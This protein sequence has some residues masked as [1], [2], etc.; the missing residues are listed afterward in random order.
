MLSRAE[1]DELV[2][3]L[4]ACSTFA[5][6]RLRGAVVER[7]P[8]HARRNVPHAP[9][10]RAF[11]SGLVTICAGYEGGLASLCEA[12][13]WYEG[14][15]YA[16]RAVYE[17][18]D[19]IGAGVSVPRD[20]RRGDMAG[21]AIARPATPVVWRPRYVHTLQRA[22]HFVD[23]IDLLAALR[24]WRG[25]AGS[26]AHVAAMV[27]LGGAGKTAV[28]ERWLAE[29][30]RSVGA[31][32]D[33]GLLVWSFFENPR[34]EAFLA[35]SVAYFASLGDETA[36]AEVTVER[37]ERALAAGP[38]HLLVLDGLE[39]VQSEGSAA[40]AYGELEDPVLR[41]LLAALARGLGR[42]RALVT[43]RFEL[44]DL[45]A[46][47]GDGLV[48]LRLSLID[49][50]S[51][52]DLLRRW[53]VHGDDRV[54]ARVCRQAGGHPLTL[55]MMG[56]YI[57]AF[58]GGDPGHVNEI[59]LDE[60]MRDDVL[61]RRL[62]AVLAEYA[63]ALSPLARELMTVLASL[64][65]GAAV[66]ALVSW[67][68]RGEPTA[69]RDRASVQRELKRLG[70]LGLVFTPQPGVY[71]THPFLRQYFRDLLDTS[72]TDPD[73][74]SPRPLSLDGRPWLPPSQASLLDTYE[75][76]L[77]HALD[78]GRTNDAFVLYARSMGSYDHLGM[79]LGDMIRGARVIRRFA[80]G[81]GGDPVSMVDGLPLGAHGKLAYE[82][83]L[84]S[85]ALG[86][87]AFAR[88]CYRV[89]LDLARS[90]R[91]LVMMATATRTLAYTERL[92][93]ALSVAREHAS[94]SLDLARQLAPWEPSDAH[95]SRALA[96]LGLICHDLGEVD[97]AASLFR[98]VLAHEALPRARRGL[99]W[100]E[101]LFELGRVGEAK[102]VTDINLTHC[103]AMRW[104]SHAAQCRLLLGHIAVSHG[105][106]AGAR[107]HLE[108]AQRWVQTTGE[109]ETQLRC[110]SLDARLALAEG[111]H[112]DAMGTASGGHHLACTTGAAWFAPGLAL[113]AAEAALA[114][115]LPMS[116]LELA[117]TGLGSES[118]WCR[119]TAHYSMGLS[120]RAMSDRAAADPHL[121]EAVTLMTQLGHPDAEAARRVLGS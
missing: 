67:V 64:L 121:T 8:A 112:A 116:A 72:E 73:Q 96:L 48:T 62:R 24:D 113:L 37:L 49:E 35:E 45:A 31:A 117:T 86:D 18:L 66:D 114:M 25:D 119:A 91:D 95:V 1:Q 55:A 109:V 13:A 6:R 80:R 44:S 3:L 104:G 30:G 20:H 99:W 85:A 82:W 10:L 102:A 81:D 118:A 4:E 76:M 78:T 70:R 50:A 38:D 40:R 59:E 90:A 98:E 51:G 97:R 103:E 58:L 111:R 36:P 105:E 57:G 5:D 94:E 65:E 56:S 33:G 101:H 106:H 21:P 75:A 23:R 11:L 2:L 54:L 7:L 74:A 29:E 42:S 115:G 34:T 79:C 46:W 71:S 89:Y 9:S 53:G 92:A 27:G 28:V 84:Y 87:I 16:M 52:L 32:H 88:R 41:R 47:E 17:F 93:G 39:A 22:R 15:S 61:A 120:Y 69:G 108:H 100:A 63:E 14:P 60:A 77:T 43:S 26:Q 12:I 19:E 110:L 68:G 107:R 83:G